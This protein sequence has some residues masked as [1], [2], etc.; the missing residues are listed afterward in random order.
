MADLSTSCNELSPYNLGMVNEL[1][2]SAQVLQLLSAMADCRTMAS[3]AL[4]IISLAPPVV[5]CDSDSSRAIIASSS[6]H[7]FLSFHIQVSH[8]DWDLAICD[9]TRAGPQP[10]CLES[11]AWCVHHTSRAAGFC[12]GCLVKMAS[13]SL[14]LSKPDT[15]MSKWCTGL[16]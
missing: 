4:Q 9:E 3:M 15:V 8:E 13:V 11:M 1:M 16:V 5:N 2:V 10:A 14:S 6:G 7:S 12:T